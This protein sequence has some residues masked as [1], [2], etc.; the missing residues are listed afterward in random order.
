[1]KG[2]TLAI[3][4]LIALAGCQGT[5]TGAAVKPT[6]RVTSH[7]SLAAS[8]G[9]NV[10]WDCTLSEKAGNY[11]PQFFVQRQQTNLRPFVM[12]LEAGAARPQQLE[13]QPDNF[14]RR[15]SLPDSSA[16]LVSSSGE[17]FA[18]DARG[19]PIEGNAIGQCRKGAQPV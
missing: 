5:G 18:I 1:M 11:P 14:A 12:M 3:G 2:R 7:A 15:Y 10:I 9:Q 8:L 19:R 17:I 6:Q 13:V 16:I 4:A